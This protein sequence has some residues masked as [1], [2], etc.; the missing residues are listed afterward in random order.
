MKLRL[1]RSHRT[2]PVALGAVTLTSVAALFVW[3]AMP[4]LFPSGAH[5][6]LGAA[7]LALIAVAYLLYQSVRR[8]G[9]AEV[10]KAVLLAIA[11]LFWAANQ[12]LPDAAA[13]TLFNDIAIGL[14]VLDVFLVIVGWPASSPDESVAEAYVESRAGETN[15]AR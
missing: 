1:D 5:D 13:A 12:L 15:A 11:F 8:P 14:F 6:W 9:A 2:L 4:T 3:D 10:L 7:P